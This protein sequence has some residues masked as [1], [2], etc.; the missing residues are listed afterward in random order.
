[1]LNNYFRSLRRFS[2]VSR[3]KEERG[4]SLCFG[5]AF[6]GGLSFFLSFLSFLPFIL[7]ATT[8]ASRWQNDFSRSVYYNTSFT[9]LFVCVWSFTHVRHHSIFFL[10]FTGSCFYSDFCRFLVKSTRSS[11]ARETRDENSQWSFKGLNKI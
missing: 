10:L 4:C 1:M 7:D 6:H 9:C 8:A 2:S 11:L 5:C 3:E